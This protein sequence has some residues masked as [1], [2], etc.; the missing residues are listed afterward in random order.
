MSFVLTLF[1][2]LGV[3]QCAEATPK[4]LRSLLSGAVCVAWPVFAVIE[5]GRD[6]AKRENLP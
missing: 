2:F 5:I 6:V 3:V 1:W 4:E